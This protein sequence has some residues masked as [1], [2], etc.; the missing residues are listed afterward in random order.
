VLAKK[1]E[2]KRKKII[3]LDSFILVIDYVRI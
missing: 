3:Y 1:N 2:K